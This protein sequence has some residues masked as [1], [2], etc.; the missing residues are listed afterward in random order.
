MY[1]EAAAALTFS[2]FPTFLY[3][4]GILI[5]LLP[6]ASRVRQ[7]SLPATE[8]GLSQGEEKEIKQCCSS[9]PLYIEQGVE[10]LLQ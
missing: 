8:A 6:A 4:I 9:I 5:S 7:R 1:K 10:I 3:L 2:L